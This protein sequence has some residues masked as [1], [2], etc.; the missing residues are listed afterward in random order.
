MGYTK[1][2]ELKLVRT[3]HIVSAYQDTRAQDLLEYI[4][5]VPFEAILTS[6]DTDGD[7]LIMTFIE[8]KTGV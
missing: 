5:H 1:D 8:E 7:E 4:K 3:K 2:L 6:W